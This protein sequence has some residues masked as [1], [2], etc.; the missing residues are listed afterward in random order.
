MFSWMDRPNLGLLVD[1]EGLMLRLYGAKT[2]G[3]AGVSCDFGRLAV[4]VFISQRMFQRD[5]PEESPV[6]DERHEWPE[7]HAASLQLPRRLLSVG[8]QS[9]RILSE[10]HED[11]RD[12]SW[13]GSGPAFAPRHTLVRVSRKEV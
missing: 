7:L 2:D 5:S 8:A 10:C 4:D 13:S 9:S 12:W 6:L 3:D 1:A 11:W